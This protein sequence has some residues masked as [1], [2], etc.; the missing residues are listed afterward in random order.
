[1]ASK[2]SWVIAFLVVTA[3]EAWFYTPEIADGDPVT[4][5]LFSVGK[6]TIGGV[7]SYLIVY[8]VKRDL[9]GEEE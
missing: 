8:M 2:I 3:I 9:S 1:M 4:R 7:V 6:Y 5:F